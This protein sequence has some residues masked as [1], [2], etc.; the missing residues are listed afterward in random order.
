[1]TMTGNG[2]YDAAMEARVGVDVQLGVGVEGRGEERETLNVVPMGMAD[3][4]VKAERLRLGLQEVMAQIPDA[5]P[6]VQDDDR[7]V[8][9]V[10]FHAC[11]VP[12][13][14]GGLFSRHGDGPAGPPEADE[15]GSSSFL[16]SGGWVGAGG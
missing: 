5:G 13:K 8:I 14:F 9:G 12:A 1:M 3:E 6:A 2:V 4:E 7:A 15:Q 10:D 11:G 16:L